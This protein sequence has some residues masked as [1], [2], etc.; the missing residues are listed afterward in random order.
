MGKVFRVL[1]V[2]ALVAA[3]GVAC[4]GDD[5]STADEFAEGST[6]STAAN[7]Q[8]TNSNVR[9]EGLAFEESDADQVLEYELIEY[10]FNGPVD[11]RAGKI[12]FEAVNRGTEDHEL[13]IL[14]ADG[15]ALGEIEAMPP[16][17][18]GAFAVE[19]EAGTYTLQCILENENGKQHAD[20]G[21]RSELVVE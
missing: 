17:Q 20:L 18:E 8:G 11:T 7:G 14:D 6:P 2:A 19:L 9:R 1:A 5:D 12:F 15:A 10:E 21:M 3:G 13:E 4:G 16:G